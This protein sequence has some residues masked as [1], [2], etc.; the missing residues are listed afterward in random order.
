MMVLLACVD[1]GNSSRKICAASTIVASDGTSSASASASRVYLGGTASLTAAIQVLPKAARLLR[2]SARRP[3]PL[4]PPQSL[5]RFRDADHI[6]ATRIQFFATTCKPTVDLASGIKS[7][8]GIVAT[9]W[10]GDE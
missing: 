7:H 1:L 5:H 4:Q 9:D 2:A 8:G 6:L 10:N 3:P